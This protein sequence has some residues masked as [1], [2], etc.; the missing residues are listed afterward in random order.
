MVKNSD[1]EPINMRLGSVGLISV[2]TVQA[3]EFILFPGITASVGMRTSLQRW[4]P[5]L[6]MRFLHLV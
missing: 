1:D 3:S 5:S 4:I 6:H 2:L